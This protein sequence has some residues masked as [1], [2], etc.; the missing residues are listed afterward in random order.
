MITARSR[1]VL[2]LLFSFV[3]T[4]PLHRCAVAIMAWDPLAAIGRTLTILGFWLAAQTELTLSHVSLQVYRKRCR[5]SRHIPCQRKCTCSRLRSVSSQRILQ[6]SGQ[7][8]V[9]YSLC[10][11]DGL[12]APSHLWSCGG[13]RPWSRVFSGAQQ[14]WCFS[15]SLTQTSSSRGRL[16]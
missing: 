14:S 15:Q 16:I 7:T 11:T 2:T 9:T 3:G 13:G 1:E 4:T 5:C 10:R 6:R 8:D 12:F